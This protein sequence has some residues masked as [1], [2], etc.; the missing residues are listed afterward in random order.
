M[1]D[2]QKK[3]AEIFELQTMLRTVAAAERWTPV[4]NPDGIYGKETAEAVRTF[5]ASRGLPATGVVDYETWTA[6][7]NA[8]QYILY[9][10][11]QGGG[12]N[13]F[14][15]RGYVSTAGEKSDFIAIMQIMLSALSVA[16]DQLA[17]LS[18]TGVYDGATAEA[19]K[20]FQRANG[21][22]ITGAV[23]MMTWDA[24]AQ[25]YN[26]FAGDRYYTH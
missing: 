2:D 4:I 23:D 15:G 20:H 14:P 25:S 16:Y 18:I 7:V 10:T 17:P 5:Q 3:R 9:I 26:E 1:T 24:L 11:S 22:P 21:L 12:I 6:L 19:V 13:P 8:Y